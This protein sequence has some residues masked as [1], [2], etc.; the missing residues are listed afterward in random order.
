MQYLSKS[1][2]TNTQ[3]AYLS[4]QASSL[5]AFVI[6][7]TYTNG[8]KLRGRQLNKTMCGS[9]SAIF[10]ILSSFFFLS[11][12]LQTTLSNNDNSKTVQALTLIS[13]QNGCSTQRAASQPLSV[14]ISSS[15][16]WSIKA[17]HNTVVAVR[18]KGRHFLILYA[19]VHEVSFPGQMPRSLA[20]ER[21]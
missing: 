15:S 11:F 19:C 20:W 7:K 18:C 1:R 4:I 17:I 2:I 13:A 10:V 12:F 21:H 8:Q 9:K 16:P 3:K 5:S 14:F 6:S